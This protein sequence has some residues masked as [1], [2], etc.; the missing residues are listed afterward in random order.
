MPKRRKDKSL[1]RGPFSAK[2]IHDGLARIG[3]TRQEGGKHPLRVSPDGKRRV[4]ISTAWTSIRVNDQLF[5]SI[6]RGAG[7]TNKQLQR[8][9]SGLDLDE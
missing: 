7:L 3:F 5:K 2:D 1:K 9:L 6:A 4:P 8:L